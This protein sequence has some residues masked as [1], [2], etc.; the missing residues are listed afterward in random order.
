MY[1]CLGFAECS[2]VG[3]KQHRNQHQSQQDFRQLDIPV[4]FLIL[5]KKPLNQRK[6]KVINVSADSF[7]GLSNE[8][9][10]LKQKYK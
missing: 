10:L 5:E 8:L 2:V 7:S 9:A 6:K 3:V 4:V 1:T